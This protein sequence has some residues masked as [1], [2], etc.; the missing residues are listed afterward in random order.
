MLIDLHESNWSEQLL[1]QITGRK[2]PKQN[3]IDFSLFSSYFYEFKCF[4]KL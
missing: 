2:E 3:M 4:D 1:T